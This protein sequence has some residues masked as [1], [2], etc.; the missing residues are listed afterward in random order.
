MAD[1]LARIDIN[2]KEVKE[3]P[4]PHRYTQPYSVVVD[5]NH[6]VWIAV[7]TTDRVARLDP[8]TERYT[9]YTL[10]TRGTEARFIS[11]DN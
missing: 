5:K 11:V 3:Y 8:T 7:M 4:L 1:Q 10:P 6:M 9:E 2:T